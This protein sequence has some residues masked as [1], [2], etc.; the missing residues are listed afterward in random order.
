MA[1]LQP[2]AYSGILQ[3]LNQRAEAERNAPPSTTGLL[4]RGVGQAAGAY[5]G[6]KVAD[7]LE[8]DQQK[9]LLIFKTGLE[10]ELEKNKAKFT[11]QGDGK[12]PIN[13][14]I[15]ND[16]WTQHT[17]DTKH[18][19]QVGEDTLYM[20][21]SDFQDIMDKGQ[22]FVERSK[23]ADSAEANDPQ[24][25]AYIRAYGMNPKENSTESST[26]AAKMFPDIAKAKEEAKASGKSVVKKDSFGRDVRYYEDGRTQVLNGASKTTPIGGVATEQAQLHPAELDTFK[27]GLNVF[28]KNVVIESKKSFLT[29]DKLQKAVED[30]NPAAFFNAK[31][32]LVLAGGVAPGR[33]ANSEI[34]QDAGTK[35][36]LGRAE[37]KLETLKTGQWS[38]ENR[39]YILDYVNTLRDIEKGYMQD[40]LETASSAT[41]AGMP[42]PSRIDPQ[43]IKNEFSKPVAKYLPEEKV[44]VISPTGTVGTLKKSKLDAALKAGYKLAPNN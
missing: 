3:M 21:P 41:L 5:A 38:S 42:D 11:A 15:V 33:L 34:V 36:A 28:D 27:K 9:D 12:M 10:T 16:Y 30:N 44:K 4:A 23:L 2:D 1:V 8:N 14:K 18:A 43:F 22:S 25:A 19:P 29:L 13:Q 37:Q 24:F 6:S 40:S 26:I 35:A 32:G 20:S 7:K 17:G 31:A 39:K